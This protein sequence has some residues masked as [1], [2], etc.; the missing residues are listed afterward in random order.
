[1]LPSKNNPRAGDPIDTGAI[2][3]CAF[4]GLPAL[5]YSFDAFAWRPTLESIVGSGLVGKPGTAVADFSRTISTRKW[6]QVA[7]Q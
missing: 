1:M 6:M 5:H 4:F 2:M 7:Q 3:L